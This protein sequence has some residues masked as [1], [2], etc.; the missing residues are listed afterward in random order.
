MVVGCQLFIELYLLVVVQA[1][2]EIASEE[3]FDGALYSFRI[4][5][6]EQKNIIDIASTGGV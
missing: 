1:L 2:G 3:R 6:L 4:I 5:Q